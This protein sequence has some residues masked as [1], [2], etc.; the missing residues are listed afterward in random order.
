M[1][2][3][4]ISEHFKTFATNS[5]EDICSHS[6]RNYVKMSYVMMLNANNIVLPVLSLHGVDI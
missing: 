6:S 2:S 5:K 1:T 3:T 4:K